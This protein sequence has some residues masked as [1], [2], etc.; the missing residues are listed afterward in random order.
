[1]G[2][3]KNALP[4]S[5]ADI[6]ALRGK[7]L[8]NSASLIADAELLLRNGRYARAFALSVIAIEEASK[9]PYLLE[10]A[11]KIV[12]GQPPDWP[13]VHEFLRSHQ[14]KLMANLMNFKRLQSLSKVPAKGTAG[15]EDAVARIREMD[16]FK[17]DGFYVSCGAIGS[18]V[19]DEKF[20][21][22]RAGM[23]LKLAQVSFNTSDLMGR[24]FDAKQAGE[25]QFD[26]RTRYTAL[27]N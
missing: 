9:I 3:L 21:D 1:M 15:W 20:D 11:E 18:A 4:L 17:Q 7:L 13:D 26:Q 10:C 27:D 25:T 12:A 22:V 5:L 14:Q 16:G 24:G 6:A 2:K 8:D 23:V 19:P